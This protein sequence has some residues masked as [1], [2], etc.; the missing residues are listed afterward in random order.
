MYKR[1]EWDQPLKVREPA[2]IAAAREQYK[3][4]IGFQMMLQYLF[5]RQW[6]CLLYTSLAQEATD[7]LL[8][9]IENGAPARRVTVPFTVI[10]GESVGP[11]PKN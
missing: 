10:H 1:Q 3:Q 2:A 6:R 5:T 8:D 11:A 7:T 9:V 4:E